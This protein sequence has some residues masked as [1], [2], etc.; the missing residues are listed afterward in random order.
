VTLQY[1]EREPIVSVYV[2]ESPGAG[3]RA[4]LPLR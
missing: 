1:V 4:E 3:K 2:A